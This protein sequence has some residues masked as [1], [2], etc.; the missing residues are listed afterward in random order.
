MLYPKV[1]KKKI[2]LKSRVND[3]CDDIKSI[4]YKIVK[5]L[6]SK[7]YFILFMK[8]NFHI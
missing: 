2:T 1:K 5:I 8:K 7:E 6:I 4:F 3:L